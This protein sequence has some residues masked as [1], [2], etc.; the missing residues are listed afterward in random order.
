MRKPRFRDDKLLSFKAARNEFGSKPRSAC[1]A[2]CLFKHTQT[3]T[4][5]QTHTHTPTPTRGLVYDTI[6]DH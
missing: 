4:D 5:T 3:H 6:P 2:Q 1:L